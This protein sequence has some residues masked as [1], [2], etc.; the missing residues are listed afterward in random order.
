MKLRPERPEIVFF[1][2]GK[3]NSIAILRGAQALLR[4]RGVAVKE[5]ILTKPSAGVPISGALL[6]QLAQ[7]RGMLLCGVND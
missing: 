3:P 6:G 4:A 5:E 1:D 2:N 7:E